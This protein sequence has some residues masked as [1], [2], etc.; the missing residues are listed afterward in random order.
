MLFVNPGKVV[1]DFVNCKRKSYFQPFPLL[2]ILSTVYTLLDKIGKVA[3]KHSDKTNDIG[4]GVSKSVASMVTFCI[5]HVTENYALL[6]VFLIPPFV[7]AVRIAFRKADSRK[8]NLVEYL[9]GGAY[10]SSLYIIISIF[11]LPFSRWLEHTDYEDSLMFFI[12]GVYFLFTVRFLYELFTGA[13]W[14]TARRTF[15]TF[16]LY[17]IFFIFY[18]IIMIC[19]TVG[20]GYAKDGI[21]SLF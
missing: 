21:V 3:E 16:C 2:I 9:F 12:W 19:L 17:S 8:Y 11:F 6:N 20:I 14:V 10:L 5:H 7:L 15:Y 4:L 1:I 13:F 18:I